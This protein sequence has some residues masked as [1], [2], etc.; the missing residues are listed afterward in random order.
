[1][2]MAW[3]G[4]LAVAIFAVCAARADEPWEGHKLSA[5]QRD[6]CLTLPRTLVRAVGQAHRLE[7]AALLRTTPAVVLDDVKA[8]EW[9]DVPAPKGGVLANRLLQDAFDVTQDRI[10]ETFGE[11]APKWS[12]TEQWMYDNL[13]RVMQTPHPPLK[14]VLVRAVAGFEGAG[15][16]DAADCGGALA[17][18][19]RSRGASTPDLAPVP[20]IVF[21]A[22]LPADVQAWREIEKP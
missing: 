9:I 12:P 15:A 3:S 14:P 21:M 1:M 19:Y 8:G 5:T 7:A 2:K 6:A 22:G 11:H 16:F 13:L 20:V 18:R 10:V 17:V 4:A